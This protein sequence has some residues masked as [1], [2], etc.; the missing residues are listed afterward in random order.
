MAWTNSDYITETNLVVRETKLRALIKEV[1]D[2]ITAAVTKGGSSRTVNELKAMRTELLV[3][4]KELVA[5]NK[6][7]TGRRA[8]RINNNGSRT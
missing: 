6:Q 8:F 7:A 4:L 2:G 5:V 1:T 3:E